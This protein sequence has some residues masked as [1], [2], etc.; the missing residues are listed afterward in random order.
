MRE[1]GVKKERTTYGSSVHHILKARG[2]DKKTMDRKEEGERAVGEGGKTTSKGKKK[3]W[4]LRDQSRWPVK[5]GR[6]LGDIFA[7]ILILTAI[8]RGKGDCECEHNTK[9]H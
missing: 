5:R 1:K 2:T 6:T 3:T 7:T 4:G 9:P 8:K